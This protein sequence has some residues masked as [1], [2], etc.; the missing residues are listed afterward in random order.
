L[1]RAAPEEQEKNEKTATDR[2]QDVRA[3]M[4]RIHKNDAGEFATENVRTKAED[5]NAHAR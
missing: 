1:I 4:H 2:A 5:A 3:T